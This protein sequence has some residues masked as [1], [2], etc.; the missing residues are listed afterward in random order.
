M[1]EMTLSILFS[2]NGPIPVY[3]LLLVCKRF[4]LGDRIDCSRFFGLMIV[5]GV[6]PKA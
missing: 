6:K 2:E 4:V 5:S 3:E 1:D